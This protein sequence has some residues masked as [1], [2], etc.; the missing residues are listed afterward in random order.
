MKK[1][2]NCWQYWQCGCEPKGRNVKKLGVCKAATEDTYDGFNSGMKAGR[3]CWKIAGTNCI[4]TL[5]GV[6]AQQIL[7]CFQ[8]SFYKKVREEENLPLLDF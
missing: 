1:K 4:D 2:Q 8:C 7:S 5:Q 6:L 3:N